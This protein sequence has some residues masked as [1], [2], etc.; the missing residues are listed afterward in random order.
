MVW[1]VKLI[2]SH[3]TEAKNPRVSKPMR[4]SQKSQSGD[5]GLHDSRITA[6]IQST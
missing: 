1:V 5:K 6:S 3:T 4:L 2:L